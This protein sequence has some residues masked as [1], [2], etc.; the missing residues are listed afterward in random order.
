[1]EY[2]SYYKPHLIKRKEIEGNPVE[3]SDVDELMTGQPSKVKSHANSAILGGLINGE[4]EVGD[5][6]DYFEDKIGRDHDAESPPNMTVETPYSQLEAPSQVE[7]TGEPQTLR[8]TKPKAR[9]VEKPNPKP[10][11]VEPEKIESNPVRED[12]SPHFHSET[13]VSA[14]AHSDNTGETVAD[15]NID[16]SETIDEGLTDANAI[17]EA[18]THRRV[19]DAPSPAEATAAGNAD[20][21][22]TTGVTAQASAT[23]PAGAAPAEGTASAAA[24]PKAEQPPVNAG[25]EAAGTTADTTAA[26]DAP[27]AS[28]QP[29]TGATPEVDPLEGAQEIKTQTTTFTM[30]T[31][32]YPAGYNESPT[33]TPKPTPQP[34]SQYPLN[35]P[36]NHGG[37]TDL[38]GP[39]T[40]QFL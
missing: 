7:Y 12:G 28:T 23:T 1:M 9:A 25:T 17:S 38:K 31:T 13:S 32:T 16:T 35:Q 29:A 39:L 40:L 5:N 2:L 30:E 22:D 4:F 21:S 34:T 6:K 36:I 37:T 14:S 27:A 3:E 19:Q 24:K 20:A 11:I 33:D 26:T 18:H 10:E 15:A 8:Q